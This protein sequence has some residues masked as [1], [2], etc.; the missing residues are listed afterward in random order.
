MLNEDIMVNICS[1]GDSHEATPD[2]PM[3]DKQMG[4]PMTR[5]QHI[6]Y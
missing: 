1:H 2:V 3:Y 4:Q 6:S 5:G